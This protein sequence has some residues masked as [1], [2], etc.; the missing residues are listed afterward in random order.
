[1]A[2][3]GFG[4]GR[5]RYKVGGC[6]GPRTVIGLLIII[7]IMVVFASIT[8]GIPLLP[9]KKAATVE[10]SVRDFVARGEVTITQ[11]QI[12]YA[13]ASVLFLGPNNASQTAPL[14]VD[15]VDGVSVLNGSFAERGRVW[16]VAVKRADIVTVTTQAGVQPSALMCGA[17]GVPVS[18]PK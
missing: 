8:R 5:R 18:A 13:G 1:M 17:L 12:A 15:P 10:A 16:C 7:A 3:F 9:P 4:A 6:L 2:G 14:L 11:G